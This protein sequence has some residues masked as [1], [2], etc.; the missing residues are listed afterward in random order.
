MKFKDRE[1]AGRHLGDKVEK[2]LCLGGK[3]DSNNVVVVGLPRGG[4]PVAF[5]VAKI[6]RCPLEII[7]SKKLPYPG[8]PEYAIGAVSSDGI[9]M[10]NTE[11]PKEPS[12]QS[13]IN[14]QRDRLVQATSKL[15]AQFYELA[16]RT[17]PLT[18]SGKTVIVVDDGVATG[19][20]AIAAVRT[21]RNRG[22]KH[23]LVASPVMSPESFEQLSEAADG[24]IALAVPEPF[25]AV[26]LF[27]TNFSPTSNEDVIEALRESRPQANHSDSYCVSPI[28][29]VG[30]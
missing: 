28:N 21:A 6:L 12:W 25:Q 26:G 4:V 18:F 30:I 14:L 20:T 11:I 2:K 29:S 16:G 8:Q 5:E 3:V 7:V 24:V 9:V 15:E 13:Y 17:R 23:T 19:M 1:E 27:Y 10:L 22:A